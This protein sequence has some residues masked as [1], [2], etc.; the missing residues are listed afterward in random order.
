MKLG[1]PEKEMA[2]IFQNRI[3][4][5]NLQ[6]RDKDSTLYQYMKTGEQYEAELENLLKI[7]DM[8]QSSIQ[9]LE[10]VI[11]SKEEII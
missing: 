3:V 8:Y 1:N 4:D 11:E 6:L 5:L 10:A 2:V 9:G 7:N